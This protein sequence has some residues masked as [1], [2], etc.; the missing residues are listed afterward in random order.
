MSKLHVLRDNPKWVYDAI[1][2]RQSRVITH[3]D[4]FYRRTPW[5]KLISLASVNNNKDLRKK[6]VLFN[7]VG[8]NNISG[9]KNLFN[10][11]YDEL[12][13]NRPMPG[14]IDATIEDKGPF[15][16]LREATI[17]IKANSIS[18]LEAIEYLYMSLG[19]HCILEWGWSVGYD[20]A[21][22]LIDVNPQF[23]IDGINGGF[24]RIDVYNFILNT[25]E[26]YNGNYN[27]IYGIISDFSWELGEDGTF[28][29][30]VKLT[31]E[32]STWLS[33]NI[34]NASK[35]TLPDDVEVEAQESSSVASTVGNF[36]LFGSTNSS[37]QRMIN[38]DELKSANGG[39]LS[40]VEA[41]LVY[42]HNNF[43]LMSGATKVD[44]VWN[45][46]DYTN[47]N[48]NLNYVATDWVN[49]NGAPGF[50]HYQKNKTSGD[51]TNVDN[52]FNYISWAFIEDYLITKN[53]SYFIDSDVQQV[54][55]LNILYSGGNPIFNMPWLQCS[56][57]R[58]AIIPNQPIGVPVDIFNTLNNL[59]PFTADD[60]KNILND[61]AKN[62]TNQ[63]GNI[64]DSRNIVP[65]APTSNATSIGSP[66]INSLGSNIFA[67]NTF[68]PN[69]TAINSQT[70]GQVTTEKYPLNPYSP[71]NVIDN[72]YQ[73]PKFSTGTEPILMSS[74]ATRGYLRR[75]YFEL[76]YVY[77]CYKQSNTLDEFVTSLLSGLSNSTGNCWEFAIVPHPI[78]QH[79][80]QIIDINFGEDNRDNYSNIIKFKIY[81]KQSIVKSVNLTTEIDSKVK[82]LVVMGSNQ[83]DNSI[84]SDNGSEALYQFYGKRV[85][86]LAF[87]GEKIIHTKQNTIESNAL[88]SKSNGEADRQSLYDSYITNVVKLYANKLKENRISKLNNSLIALLNDTKKR[89]SGT[90]SPYVSPGA[91]NTKW[92]TLP[93][94]LNV[95]IDGISGLYMGNIIDIDY[96]P[97]RYNDEVIFAIVGVEHT[98]NNSGWDVKYEAQIRIKNQDSMSNTLTPQA[99]SPTNA[100]SNIND[101]LK[102]SPPTIRI[103]KSTGEQIRNGFVPDKYLVDVNPLYIINNLSADMRLEKYAAAAFDDLSEYIYKTTGYKLI[104]NSM[105]RS[106]INQYYIETSYAKAKPGKS[107]HGFGLAVDVQ[108]YS[109]VR[110]D[111]SHLQPYITELKK[112]ALKYG[113]KWYSK[114]NPTTGVLVDPVHW[115]YVKTNSYT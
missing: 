70:M 19:V 98:I 7:G 27:A 115:E 106:Y 22:K 20:V 59:K 32:G 105:Y 16:A 65:L 15:G 26:L 35:E 108:Y 78:Y 46:K 25:T 64:G 91:G 23:P 58:I 84:S 79:V 55:P 94:S 95:T 111:E 101:V 110:G 52:W 92:I 47:T 54:N 42:L 90:E 30:T 71:S 56:D 18:Q 8:D 50:V 89:I 113:F 1:E 48:T 66:V 85:R 45:G 57:P 39:M 13:N 69:S 24:D 86:D 11:R 29:C 103:I 109:G 74:S 77:E 41:T 88:G 62:Q 73:A 67:Q 12:D 31:A 17:N 104:V 37:A 81:N 99:D 97:P 9:N 107:L 28:N 6:W 72:T 33:T 49:N 10:R 63:L 75:I 102:Y 36:W 114:R 38:I 34:N 2:L 93:L 100:L 5:I 43:T 60:G 53:I 3:D 76:T 80:L 4:W 44:R 112:I 87:R 40:N 68:I 14:I 83:S 96:K 51:N 82:S 21:G 61:Y